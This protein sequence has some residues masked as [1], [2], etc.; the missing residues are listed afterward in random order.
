MEK[1]IIQNTKHEEN[2]EDDLDNSLYEASKSVSMASAKSTVTSSAT[3]KLIVVDSEDLSVSPLLKFLI[4]VTIS[5]IFLP[6]VFSL[7]RYQR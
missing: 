5:C 4:F 6:L 1:H 3:D 2:D 7:C